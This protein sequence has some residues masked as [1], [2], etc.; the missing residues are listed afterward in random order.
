MVFAENPWTSATICRVRWKTLN[1]LLEG[2]QSSVT[3]H[4]ATSIVLPYARTKRLP[5]VSSSDGGNPDSLIK[6]AVQR[7]FWRPTSL[8]KHAIEQVSRARCRH[9]PYTVHLAACL[10]SLYSHSSSACQR[11]TWGTSLSAR[12]AQRRKLFTCYQAAEL[13]LHRRTLRGV[14]FESRWCPIISDLGSRELLILTGCWQ[15]S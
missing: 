6:P 14:T 7:G 15:S 1:P 9:F 5:E 3:Y 11:C 12:A 8:T 10:E 2:R 4:R 13:P